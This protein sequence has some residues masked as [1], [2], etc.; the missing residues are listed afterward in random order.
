[1]NMCNLFYLERRKSYGKAVLLILSPVYYSD[2]VIMHNEL[3][4]VIAIYKYSS[5]YKTQG[6]ITA[7]NSHTERQRKPS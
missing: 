2:V 4:N 5:P 7:Q 3:E 1:M 6:G